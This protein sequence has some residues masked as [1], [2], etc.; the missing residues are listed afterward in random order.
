[1]SDPNHSSS[2]SELPSEGID[3][4][5]EASSV[6]SYKEDEDDFR[7]YDNTFD[8]IVNSIDTID[9]IISEEEFLSLRQTPLQRRHRNSSLADSEL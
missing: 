6:T 1:M 9:S 3:D 7:I 5:S 2:E 4:V 8:E